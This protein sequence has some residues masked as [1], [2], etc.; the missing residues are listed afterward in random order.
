[1]AR[2]PSD[3]LYGLL[4]AAK[5]ANVG[6][7][8]YNKRKASEKDLDAE[9]S[10]L[11]G[12]ERLNESQIEENLARAQYYKRGAPGRTG[13]GGMTLPQIRLAMDTL[14]RSNLRNPEE[15]SQL[16][17]LRE[18]FNSRLGIKPKPVHAQPKTPQTE[19]KK[20]FFDWY[21]GKIGNLGRSLIGLSN[22][23]EPKMGNDPLGLR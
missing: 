5:A 2:G 10:K 15:D 22:K 21:G 23:I 17:A 18:E 3:F 7:E 6:V 13:L 9:K 12:A 14:Q 4:G 20:G 16:S 11:A 1:M 8:T 19:P